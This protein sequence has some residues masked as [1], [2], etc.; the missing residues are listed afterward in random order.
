MS[1]A[2]E[3]E[4]KTEEATPQKLEKAKQKGEGVKTMDLQP[5]M[6]LAAVSGVL[7]ISGGWFTRNLAVKLLPFLAHP[8]AMSVEGHGGMEIMRYALLAA[9]PALLT[10]MLTAAVAG[11]SASLMQSGLR[12][13]AEKL[14]PDFSKLDPRKGL[15]RMFGLDGVV[16]FAKSLVKVAV[17]ALLVWCI[18]RPVV[19]KFSSLSALDVGSIMPFCVDIL[20][21]LVFSVVGVSLAVAGADWFWQRQRFLVRMRMT[22]EEVKEEYKNT[23]GDPHVKARQ[24]QVRFER[25]KRRMMQAVPDATVV[26][27]NPTHYA[28]ALKYEQGDTAAPVCVAKGLDSLALKIRAVA[29]EAGVPVIEDPPLARAL[30]AAVDIDEMIPPAHFEAVA[31]IIGFILGAGRRRALHR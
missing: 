31:K 24:K 11:S 16:Q 22:K 2:P 30:Y 9:A 13:S 17:I 20:K 25:A 18:L 26:V 12:L 5:A 14:K 19:P 10:V 15:Q 1:E 4:S 28:V 7:I 6:V 3:R 23:E 8:D 27:M 29:E 21:R